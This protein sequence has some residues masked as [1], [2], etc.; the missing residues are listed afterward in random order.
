MALSAHDKGKKGSAAATAA[1]TS[2]TSGIV[3]DF[4]RL[5]HI[6]ARSA[7]HRAERAAGCTLFPPPPPPP[8]S[9]RLAAMLP[10][11]RT[12]I[13]LVFLLCGFVTSG[14]GGRWVEG[15]GGGGA[16]VPAVWLRDVQ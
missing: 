13:V 14:E 10:S 8:R 9:D 16:R 4:D 6:E 11:Q 3:L 1:P 5:A 15:E 2:R 7:L 12:V